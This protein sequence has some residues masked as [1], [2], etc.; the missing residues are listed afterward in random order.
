MASLEN[1]ALWHERDLTHSSVERVIIPDSCILLDYMLEKFIAVIEGLVVYEDNMARNIETTLGLV[2]SQ[3][4]LLALVGKGISR[5]K[6][7]R[8][9]QDNA[10]RSWREK[11]PFKQLL[12]ADDAIMSLITP[13]ELDGIFD[14]GVYTANVD[15][16]FKRSGL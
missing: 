14:Y 5:E 4:L 12:L 1:V 9:V 15:Y 11:I 8:M 13:G 10:M 3:Q 6:S 16:I 2:F 7:Y